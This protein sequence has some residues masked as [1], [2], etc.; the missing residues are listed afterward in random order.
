[1]VSPSLHCIHALLGTGWPSL[2]SLK[3]DP[4][5][6]DNP[7]SST[8]SRFRR[9][10]E[11]S[12]LWRRVSNETI[13]HP[14]AMYD[15]GRLVGKCGEGSKGESDTF[16]RRYILDMLKGLGPITVVG[17]HE[18]RLFKEQLTPLLTS[19]AVRPDVAVLCQ[20]DFPLL[21]FE[22]HSSPFPC[23]IIQCIVLATDQVRLHRLFTPNS[24]VCTAFALPKLNNKQCVVRVDVKW[25]KFGFE[26]GVLFVEDPSQVESLIVEAAQKAL[27]NRPPT[28]TPCGK[29]MGLIN[30][31]P[32]ECG[33]FGVVQEP[34]QGA[35]ILRSKSYI[36]KCPM[37]VSEA[38]PYLRGLMMNTQTSL[39]S[40][41]TTMLGGRPFYKYKVVPYDPLRCNEAMLCL[42]DF[43]QEV[44]LA[45]CEL[46]SLGFAHQD[47]RLPNICFSS[48]FHPVLIDLDQVCLAD[49][50]PSRCDGAMYK[51]EFS[52]EKNDWLQL[53]LIILWIISPPSPQ[54]SYY[55]EDR[56]VLPDR[57]ISDRFLYTLMAEGCYKA[58]F[59]RSSVLQRYKKTLRDVLEARCM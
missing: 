37:S 18:L 54:Q 3:M 11:Q 27:Q 39:I 50:L 1:M 19:T 8:F 35:I 58:Q 44:A 25:N 7:S 16:A 5:P 48:D 28:L 21:C 56:Q 59:L 51:K 9:E 14:P 29:F 30:L 20:D 40:I 6:M 52:A 33:A 17:G 13:E 46:H 34:S 49:N 47:I 31:S 10:F 36:F 53:G 2:V 23:T 32:E 42:L 57:Y 55:N 45:I 15:L 26:Y 24:I 41:S 38:F 43:T 4:P 12:T 22:V